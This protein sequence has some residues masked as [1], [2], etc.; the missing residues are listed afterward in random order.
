VVTQHIKKTTA[1]FFFGGVKFFM[2]E[3]FYLEAESLKFW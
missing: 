2:A 1:T 3:S